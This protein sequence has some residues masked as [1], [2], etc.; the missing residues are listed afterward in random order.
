MADEH[1]PSHRVPSHGDFASNPADIRT[2]TIVFLDVVGSTRYAA[3]RDLEEFDSFIEDTLTLIET[4]VHSY[5]GQLLERWGDGALAVFGMVQDAEDAAIAAIASA[6]AIC[7][8]APAQCGADL[9]AGL[10][11][12]AV[13]CRTGETPALPKRVTGLDVAIASRLQQCAPSGTVAVSPETRSFTQ[14]IATLHA[15]PGKPFIPKGLSEPLTPWL[16]TGLTHNSPQGQSVKTILGR[17]EIV[18]RLLR[19]GAEAGVQLIAGPAGVGKSVLAHSVARRHAAQERG[20]QLLYLSG[21]SNLR[22]SSLFPCVEFL[23]RFLEL[24]DQSSI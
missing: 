13:M 4:T 2:L 18:S 22:R 7:D 24:P 11:S 12:G 3:H 14:R 20:R 19:C 23:R 5:G 6:L 21:R 17:E 10:H 1:S 16:V 8:A 15:A 9:R